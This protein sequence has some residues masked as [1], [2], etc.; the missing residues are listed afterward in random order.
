[1][2]ASFAKYN[3]SARHGCLEPHKDRKGKKSDETAAALLARGREEKEKEKENPHSLQSSLFV[4]H[5]CPE[6]CSRLNPPLL[7]NSSPIPSIP[8]HLH[9]SP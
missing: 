6:Y 1:M 3:E 8:T 5:S 7:L 2:N 4:H 9:I